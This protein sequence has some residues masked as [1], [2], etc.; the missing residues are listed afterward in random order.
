M[1][2]KILVVEDEQFVRDLLRKVLAQ[3]GHTVLT[4]CDGVEALEMLAAEPVDLV[5]TDVV[6]PRMEGF[7]LLCRVKREY[8]GIPVIVLTGYAR[9]QSISDFL[10]HGA[11]EYLAKPFL[12]PELLAAVDRSLGSPAGP[13]GQGTPGA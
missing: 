12:V 7:E 10:L 1:S 3:R 6:M 11:D 13:V 4:A 8:P 5:L 9:R 2:G